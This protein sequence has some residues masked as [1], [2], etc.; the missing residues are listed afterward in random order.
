MDMAGYRI[1]CYRPLV[2]GSRVSEH[3]D[4]FS[5]AVSVSVALRVRGSGWLLGK[6]ASEKTTE[7]RGFFRRSFAIAQ[8]RVPFGRAKTLGGRARRNAI[9]QHF[10]RSHPDPL[11]RSA[12]ASRVQSV[13][14][15]LTIVGV[16]G[17]SVGRRR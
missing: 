2:G 12:T 13:P 16:V 9:T 8:R 14:S 5:Y 4:G 6:C 10:P 17:A 3:E 11:T 1:Y 15:I 7:D